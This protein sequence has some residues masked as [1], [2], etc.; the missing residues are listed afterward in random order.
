[1]VE[2][3]GGIRVKDKVRAVLCP[4]LLVATTDNVP[5][6]KDAP[7]VREILVVPCPEEI[8][9]LVGAVHV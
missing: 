5:L 4:Q 8:V 1:M 2:G 9:V 6:V 3:V 7:T